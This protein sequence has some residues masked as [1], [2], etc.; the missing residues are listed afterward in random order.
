MGC[1]LISHSASAATNVYYSVGQSSDSL[2]TGTGTIGVSGTAATF[3]TAQTGNIGVG[4]K[5]TYDT[6]KVCYIAAKTSTT[7][8][9]CV[10]ATG[11]QPEQVS[12]GT[13]LNSI[14]R[15]YTSLAA[16]VN[17]STG[18]P[19][20]IGTTNLVTGNYIVNIPC[21]YD[22]GPDTT[23]TAIGAWTTSATNYIKIYTPQGGS[24]SNNSQRHS[25]TWATNKY[26]LE[27]DDWA[28]DTDVDNKIVGLRIDGLQI[29][30]TS[31]INQGDYGMS[32]NA[33][34]NAQIYISNNIVR[35][36]FSGSANEAYGI[37]I[38]LSGT[39]STAKVWNNIVYDFKNGSG[40]TAMYGIYLGNLSA[41]KNLYAYNNTVYNS[42]NCYGR[43][44][45]NFIAK[46]NIA[47]S[48]TD[49]FVGTFTAS[50]YNISNVATDAPSA[51]YR[52]NE[53]TTV[54]F[55][56]KDNYDLHLGVGDTAAINTGVTIP[57][58]TDLITDIDN[59]T[60][61]G[62]WDIGADEYVDI[63]PLTLTSIVISDTSG[64][65]ND[66]TPE[67][68]IVS[69]GSPSDMAF[70]CNNT[71]WSD[72]ITYANPT[73]AFNITTGAGCSTG[74]GNKT[75]YAKLK[76]SAGNLSTIASDSINYDTTPSALSFNGVGNN[77][78]EVG[79]VASDTIAATW[80]DATVTKWEYSTTNSCST[81]STDYSH[82]ST[83]ITTQTTEEHNG[84]YICLYGA[85]AAGNKST[86]ASTNPIHVHTKFSFQEFIYD[87]TSSQSGM[88]THYSP[89]VPNQWMDMHS[90]YDG[91]YIWY[92][93]QNSVDHTNNL[94]KFNPVDNFITVY[95]LAG[96]GTDTAPIAYHAIADPLDSNI[97]W[98]WSPY[99][100][101]SLWKFNKTTKESTYI[102][103]QDRVTGTSGGKIARFTQANGTS[104][105]WGTLVSHTANKGV[106]PVAYD[107]NTDTFTHYTFHT[108]VP[109]V[110]NSAIFE[111][112][113]L[114]ADGKNL[115]IASGGCAYIYVIHNNFQTDGAP[116]DLVTTPQI[117]ATY[118]RSSDVVTYTGDDLVNDGFSDLAWDGTYLWAS[119]GM[120][121]SSAI[122]R[123]KPIF[124]GDGYVTGF[125][126]GNAS[127]ANQPKKYSTGNGWVYL[128]PSIKANDKYVMAVWEATTIGK[129][130]GLLI[131]K[132]NDFSTYNFA[133][134]FENLS[135]FLG[136]VWNTVTSEI[137]VSGAIYITGYSPLLQ[138]T[139]FCGAHPDVCANVNSSMHI[140]KMTPNP[141]LSFTD[142]VAVGPVSSDTITADW[143]ESLTNKKKWDYDADGICSYV[144]D[145]YDYT[146]ST[147]IDQTTIEH[148][149]QYICLYGEDAAGNKT[150]LASANPINIA[151]SDDDNNHHGAGYKAYK[152]LK[153]SFGNIFSKRI[154]TRVKNIKNTNSTG[155]NNLKTIYNQYK[156][157]SSGEIRKISLK[158]YEL[159]KQYKNYR[160][161]KSYKEYRAKYH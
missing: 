121:T 135:P 98:V 137:D 48:C 126:D 74:D 157:L 112:Y 75:I 99:G 14:K 128:A 70:S 71:D 73:S 40:G 132:T 147:P 81:T 154:Y 87:G 32:F 153:K 44:Q 149:G 15:V 131:D 144:A 55:V 125:Y 72:W 127:D 66:A 95:P 5:V 110:T 23:Y 42:Y 38:F 29:K 124:D 21:Y 47:Q 68:T 60:R 31:T 151:S 120:G 65:T 78:V 1:F 140:L 62:N 113:G 104:R 111:T 102:S 18:I 108:D 107:E 50:D 43:V 59:Q 96:Y 105:I 85:D 118:I 19:V 117:Q 16:A 159:F 103:G 136:D 123:I 106:S 22:N 142:D 35:G 88:I 17:V 79:P 130:G 82:S 76:D 4:D 129:F 2:E 93:E 41:G 146:D 158:I 45:G 12:A 94:I 53:A 84:K 33:G 90:F 57:N 64:Y 51:S 30:L 25:G 54:S 109:G 56:D 28:L 69:S 36:N 134:D 152:K 155:F 114:Q 8:W 67:I 100:T 89:D 116:I 143:G 92:P 63:T 83:S 119:G 115:F 37:Q 133:G 46:N 148:S 80:G 26:R 24:E 9:S 150:T 97:I 101:D 27:V 58:D 138:G 52:P 91:T 49:G 39:S 160:G 61:S 34:T 156:K 141:Y 139:I 13:A 20:G 161:Y 77:N 10:S 6:N 122:F 145:D 11:G 3:S 86:L 7:V